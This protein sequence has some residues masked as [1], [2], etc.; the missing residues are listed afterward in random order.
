LPKKMLFF[1]LSLTGFAYCFVYNSLFLAV[2]MIQ[3]SCFEYA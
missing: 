1:L 3:A 2:L